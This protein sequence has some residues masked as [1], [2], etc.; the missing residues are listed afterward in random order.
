M[1]I[2]LHRE[3]IP[4]EKR[5]SYYKE[6]SHMLTLKCNL[7]QC[8]F[9]VSWFYSEYDTFLE[10]FYSMTEDLNKSILDWLQW[11]KEKQVERRKEINEQRK[12]S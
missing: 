4:K 9:K 10:A 1:E 5:P 2:K 6:Y 3:Y 11:T 8:I 12:I 7:A